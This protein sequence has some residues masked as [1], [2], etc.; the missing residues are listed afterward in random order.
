MP[1]ELK[2]NAEKTLRMVG[3]QIA[4]GVLFLVFGIDI[5]ISDAVIHALQP[6][7]R[8]KEGLEALTAGGLSA[9]ILFVVGSLNLGVASSRFAK[10]LRH[11]DEKK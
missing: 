4:A 10:V 2:E 11:I 3:W 7:E 6:F 9:N 8:A 5:A 1:T